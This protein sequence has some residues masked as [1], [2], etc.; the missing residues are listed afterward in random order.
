MNRPREVYQR[1]MKSENQ[2]PPLR[3]RQ[4]LRAFSAPLHTSDSGT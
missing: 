2:T 1:Q 3:R 4:I